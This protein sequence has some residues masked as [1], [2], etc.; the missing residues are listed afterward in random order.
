M[1]GLC[2]QCLLP[3][4]QTRWKHEGLGMVGVLS[5]A[6]Y[7]CCMH[8][9]WQGC[10]EMPIDRET[11][12]VA[13]V[14]YLVAAWASDL[15]AANAILPGYVMCL[16]FFT[17]YP[18]RLQVTTSALFVCHLRGA[19][20]L[21]NVCLQLL[22][23]MTM[24]TVLQDLPRWIGWFHY[25]DFLHYAWACLMLNQFEDNTQPFL[26]NATARFCPKEPN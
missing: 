2:M 13:V 19:V 6:D 14:G 22:V 18:L 26:G 25:L 21:G 20:S 5:V 16:F 17:G 7:R 11:W 23:C 3:T 12:E 8:V 15:D 9:H 24:H 10:Y 1:L 4:C